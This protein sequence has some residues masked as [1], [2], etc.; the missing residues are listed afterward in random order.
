[1]KAGARWRIYLPPQLGYG[2]QG[3]PPAIEPNEVLVF[4]I[5]LIGSRPGGGR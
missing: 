1:M 3:S 4:E 5:Q 2:V